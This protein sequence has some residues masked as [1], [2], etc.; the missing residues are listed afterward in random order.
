MVNYR[1]IEIFAL[2]NYIFLFKK[3]NVILIVTK[4]S[5]RFPTQSYFRREFQLKKLS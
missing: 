5:L 1:W 4:I 3:N 2:K